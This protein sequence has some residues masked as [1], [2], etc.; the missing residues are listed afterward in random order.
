MKK[1]HARKLNQLADKIGDIQTQIMTEE[2][3]M[4]WELLLSGFGQDRAY[5][6]TI[7]PDRQYL[8]KVPT[9]VHQSSEKELKRNFNKGGVKEVAQTVVQELNKRKMAEVISKITA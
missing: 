4:G 5:A 3:I 7:V 6:K 8:L 1:K 2:P 9:I